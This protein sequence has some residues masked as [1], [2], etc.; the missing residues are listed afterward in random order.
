MTRHG[1]TVEVRFVVDADSPEQA[2]EWLNRIDLDLCALS[3]GHVQWINPL[4]DDDAIALPA[5]RFR[6]E[7]AF[8]H[9]AGG[10]PLLARWSPA[11]WPARTCSPRSNHHELANGHVRSAVPLP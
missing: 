10:W 4:E 8:D 11:A 9:G 2:L 6:D 7:R 5:T 3:L 1:V